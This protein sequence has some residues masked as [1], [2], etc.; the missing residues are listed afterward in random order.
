MVV[1][2]LILSKGT[3]TRLK[4]KEVVSSFKSQKTTVAWA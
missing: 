3:F 4:L 2:L 1:D